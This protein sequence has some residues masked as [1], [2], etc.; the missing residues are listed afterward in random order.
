MRYQLSIPVTALA[1]LALAACGTERGGGAGS[2]DT[3]APDVPLAG[4]RWSVES[5]SV[6][7]TKTASP[8]DAYVEITDKGR[9]QGNYGCNHFGADITVE[10]DTVTVGPGEV[11]EMACDKKIQ[12]F[13]DALRAAFSGKL[14]AKLTDGRLTLTTEKGDTIALTAERPSPLIGT[15]WTVDSLVAD[16][17]ATSL[18]AGTEGKAHL[19][20]AEDGTVGGSLGCN[21]FTST[22]KV[23]GDSITFGRL[24]STRK[25][26]P[27]PVMD[28]ERELV[29]VLKQGTVKYEVKHRALTLTASNGKGLAAYADMR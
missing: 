25:L 7:G 3:V 10:G 22:A 20:I 23:S 15:K 5:V 2:G 13:E 12:G 18:P 28:L 26:C 27:G 24:A 17:T 9:A 1:L 8:S 14:K 6:D 21:R 11:T 29:Q 4:V 19:T 16:E